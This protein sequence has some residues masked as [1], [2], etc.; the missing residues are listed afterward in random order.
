MTRKGKKAPGGHNP[1]TYHE[2]SRLTSYGT[3]TNRLGTDSQRK[4]GDCCLGLQPAVDPVATPSGH[5]YSRE[6]IVSYLLSKNRDLKEQRRIYNEKMASIRSKQEKDDKVLAIQSLE[7]FEKKDHGAVQ[8]SKDL[9]TKSLDMKLGNKIN[10]ETME[11]SQKALK[12]TSYWLS[13]YQ[14]DYDKDEELVARGPPPERPSSPMS[15]EPLKL[16]NLISLKLIKD[17]SDDK[18]PRFVCAV[19]RDTLTTQPV[20]VIKKTGQVMLKSV[21]KKLVKPSMICP[22]TSKKFKE[23]DVIELKKAASAFSASGKVQAKK[24]RHTLT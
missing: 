23:K 18:D 24:Y 7:Q 12:R 22:I 8:Q 19:S 21:Y 2:R 3:T 10:T 13:E 14:P 1:L 9:H 16:K 15:G 11:E 5:I 4:F 17:E 20:I 6:A